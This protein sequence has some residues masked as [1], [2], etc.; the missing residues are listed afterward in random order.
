MPDRCLTPEVS[1][2]AFAAPPSNLTDQNGPAQ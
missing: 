2:P 1:V